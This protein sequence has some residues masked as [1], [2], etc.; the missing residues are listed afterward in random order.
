MHFAEVDELGYWS[1]VLDHADYPRLRFALGLSPDGV[2]TGFDV[3]DRRFRARSPEPPG[4]SPKWGPLEPISRR[5]IESLPFGELERAARARVNE[6]L[7]DIAAGKL[8]LGDDAEWMMELGDSMKNPAR[9]GRPSLSDRFLAEIPRDIAELVAG[10]ARF[11][12]KE[13]AAA[14]DVSPNTAKNWR[15]EAVRRGLLNKSAGGSITTKALSI[16][17][18]TGDKDG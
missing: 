13:L 4:D 18:Q 17:E 6:D 9:G 2:V 12:I 5:L 14:R 8:D 1:L 3:R 15:A 7:G 16:L 11:P 10:E